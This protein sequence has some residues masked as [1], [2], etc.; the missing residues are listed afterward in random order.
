MFYFIFLQVEKLTI[1]IDLMIHMLHDLKKEIEIWFKKWRN[2]PLFWVSI[3]KNLFLINLEKIIC[4]I[5]YHKKGYLNEIIES[6]I[7]GWSFLVLF[8]KFEISYLLIFV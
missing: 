4:K 8:K 7:I 3:W 6:S 1:Q 5:I 2:I